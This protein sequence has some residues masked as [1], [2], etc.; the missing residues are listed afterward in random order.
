MV[1]LF[2]AHPASADDY[3]IL[4]EDLRH[5]YGIT[6]RLL[7]TSQNDSAYQ[8]WQQL[9]VGVSAEETPLFLD[10][11]AASC[12]FSP[13]WRLVSRLLWLIDWLGR[14]HLASF[15]H[16]WQQIAWRRI[17]TRKLIDTLNPSVAVVTCD[18]RPTISLPFLVEFRKRQIPVLVFGAAIIASPSE[19]LANR[20]MKPDCFPKSGWRQILA[21]TLPTGFD[22]PK[23][24]HALF[25]D[26]QQALA[27]R[28]HGVRPNNLWIM[29]GS[30][31]AS[32]VA[33]L[34]EMEREL[35][36]SE[37]GLPSKQVSVVGLPSL[38]WLAE[39]DSRRTTE[40]ATALCQQYGLEDD[41][42]LAIFAV[43]QR[44]S[45]APLFSD[46]DLK[47][48]VGSLVRAGYSTLCSIHPKM[49]R[50]SQNFLGD[51]EHCAVSELPLS[52]VLALASVFLA[53]YSSTLTWAG[54][55][56]IPCAVVDFYEENSPAYRDIEDL[57]IL[58]N[59]QAVER[60]AR[61]LRDVARRKRL[62][63]S[64]QKG[65]QRYQ[66]PPGQACRRLADLVESFCLD[67]RVAK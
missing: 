66:A 4:A 60:W 24:R 38:D 44:F 33:V 11:I 48:I 20:R 61:P 3:R 53:S 50:G 62:G 10:V 30:G 55:L 37:P 67:A 19:L 18:R 54:L 21:R 65:F 57:A 39:L 27:V 17:A 8:R 31:L 42:P 1:I 34:G 26:I 12:R 47:A 28:L 14:S 22:Q 64:L 29:G 35:C 2:C 15:C 23:G 40:E 13:V 46:E 45:D 5:R 36:L 63:D 52:N 25:I 9:A 16:S 7:F 58:R 56:S 43:P 51:L 49:P 41:R 6:T 32:H 59:A